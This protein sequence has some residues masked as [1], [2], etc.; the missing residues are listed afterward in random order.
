[1]FINNIIARCICRFAL[2]KPELT[3]CV[4]DITGS[5]PTVNCI[6]RQL[7]HLNSTVPTTGKCSY[8]WDGVTQHINQQVAHR[9]A[10]AQNQEEASGQSN[11]PYSPGHPGQPTNPQSLSLI[12][13]LSTHFKHGRT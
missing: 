6:S 1:M 13:T 8:H 11:A 5:M 2:S 7:V 10:Q 12:S 3:Y 9:L 4:G